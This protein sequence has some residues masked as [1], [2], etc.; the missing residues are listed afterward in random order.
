MNHRYQN[1][2][3]VETSTLKFKNII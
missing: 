2:I 1:I 3:F